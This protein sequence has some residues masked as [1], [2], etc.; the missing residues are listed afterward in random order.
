[1]K[2]KLKEYSFG[3]EVKFINNLKRRR[4]DYKCSSQRFWKP[5]VFRLKWVMIDKLHRQKPL[6]TTGIII[7]IRTLRDG[8]TVYVGYDGGN[9]A[10]FICDKTFKAY[11]VAIDMK[12]NP[13]YVLPKDI[14]K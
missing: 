1:M 8:H 7:G 5:D 13:V 4:S 12:R 10:S 9:E 3:D 2:I 14:I 11:L 6:I